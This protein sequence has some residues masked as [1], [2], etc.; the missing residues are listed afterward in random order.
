MLSVWSLISIHTF[1][2]SLTLFFVREKYLCR[3]VNIH[4][5]RFPAKNC[6]K[7]KLVLSSVIL[8]LRIYWGLSSLR[9]DKAVGWPFCENFFDLHEIS[10]WPQKEVWLVSLWE[11]FAEVE[12]FELQM[13]TEWKIFYRPVLFV[14]P[15]CACPMRKISLATSEKREWKS[16][17][18]Q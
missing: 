8:V 3:K 1:R 13:R 7:R 6:R 12:I 18:M 15:L 5:L 9:P 2:L 11:N 17:L 14:S 16:G 10:T 4:F